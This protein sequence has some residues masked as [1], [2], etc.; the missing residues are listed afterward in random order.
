MSETILTEVA[1]LFGLPAQSFVHH[2]PVRE[3]DGVTVA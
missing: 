2:K 3:P 1:G